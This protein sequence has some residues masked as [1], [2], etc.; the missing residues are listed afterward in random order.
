MPAIFSAR[1]PP[2]R[3]DR[4]I[5]MTTEGDGISREI[6]PNNRR[7]VRHRDGSNQILSKQELQIKA[8]PCNIKLPTLCIISS[9]TWAFSL[10]LWDV[11]RFCPT[12]FPFN[13]HFGLLIFWA[14]LFPRQSSKTFSPSSAGYSRGREAEKLSAEIWNSSPGLVS[15]IPDFG[16]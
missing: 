1:I 11:A 16:P 5:S 9:P 3:I 4:V 8:S 12:I 13:A 6:P 15:Q 14:Q 10:C 2:S 7:E